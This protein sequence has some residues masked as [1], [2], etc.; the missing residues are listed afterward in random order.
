MRPLW[1]AP[2]FRTVVVGAIAVAVAV[3]A[4]S[5]TT[6]P[7]LRPAGTVS[8]TPTL[9][10][11]ANGPV[12]AITVSSTR[13]Y[14]GGA[15][16]KVINA[17]TGE[18]VYRSRLAAF[19]RKSGALVRSWTPRTNYAVRALVQ[20][21]GQLIAGGDFTEFKNPSSSVWVGAEHLAVFSL[22]GVRDTT[23]HGSTDAS[24]H[25]IVPYGARVYIAGPFH[26]V[27]SVTP[28]RQP[29]LAAIHRSNGTLDRTWTPSVSTGG[30]VY[31]L[32]LGASKTSIVV[33]GKF[34]TIDGASRVNLGRVSTT[35]GSVLDWTPAARCVRCYVESLAINDTDVFAGMAGPGGRVVAYRSS[36]GSTR[37]ARIA[38]GNVQALR[39]LDGV[40]FIGGHFS[41][42][43]GIPRSQLA[44]LVAVNGG[45][46]LFH[47]A[48]SKPYH[49]G[50]WVINAQRDYIRVGG[51]FT[52]VGSVKTAH[53]VSFKYQP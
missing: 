49:P 13:V 26:H 51:A 47:P 38:N 9:G 45:L 24:V 5:A 23:W 50:V 11:R 33:G 29:N 43:N 44:S 6:Q 37:W 52:G 34:S 19:S 15:F 8:S 30:R 7:A 40:L 28:S 39:Y 27:G 16:T 35:N 42:V 41:K 22:G 46:R 20:S 25:K 17:N 31:A 3:P 1:K 12:Y 48:F 32:A 53:Y 21:N 14:I 4:A 36:G 10:W 18:R 2:L